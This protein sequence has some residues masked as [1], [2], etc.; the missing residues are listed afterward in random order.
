MESSMFYI[1]LPFLWSQTQEFGG[2]LSTLAWFI[3]VFAFGEY[4][5]QLVWGLLYNQMKIKNLM[6]SSMI[7]GAIGALLFGLSGNFHVHSTTAISTDPSLAPIIDTPSQD[8]RGMQ[9]QNFL[10]N[11]FSGLQMI[12]WA[13]LLQGIWQG[14]ATVITHAY[15]A[16]CLTKEEN[17][18]IVNNLTMAQILGM[19]VG[20][21]LG[22]LLSYINFSIGSMIFNEDTIIGYFQLLA[23]V[24]IMVST[25]LLFEE[26]P[27]INREN[28]NNYATL[29]SQEPK[30]ASGKDDGYYQSNAYNTGYQSGLNEGYQQFQQLLM[31]NQSDVY[32]SAAHY[33]MPHYQQNQS[34]NNSDSQIDI[35]RFVKNKDLIEATNMTEEEIRALYGLPPNMSGVMIA[36]LIQASIMNTFSIFETLLTPIVTD[37]DGLITDSMKLSKNYASSFFIIMSM[38]GLLG[39]FVFKKFYEQQRLNKLSDRAFVFVTLVFGLI[40]SLVLI[41]YQRRFIYQPQALIGFCLLSVSYFIGRRV[42]NNMFAKLIGISPSNNSAKYLFASNFFIAIV[43]ISAAYWNVTAAHEGMYLIFGVQSTLQ[44]L[45]IVFMTLCIEKLTPHYSYL[46]EKQRE[47]MM[48]RALDQDGKYEGSFHQRDM[49]LLETPEYQ[50]LPMPIHSSQK[51][52]II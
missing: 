10:M 8:S 20:P 48:E 32:P 18:R 27:K 9:K 5:G 16:E 13:R 17:I 3:A 36:F 28:F 23:I 46:I 33:N 6:I 1:V 2:I 25:V 34:F 44:L 49:R 12:G 47:I 51:V 22:I 29:R 50:G 7:I 52:G 35:H 40:G 30:L 42:T 26:I 45:A 31:S 21:F 38:F 37:T 15:V 19:A 14:S 24:A 43:R 39:F 11:I 41:D 4:I